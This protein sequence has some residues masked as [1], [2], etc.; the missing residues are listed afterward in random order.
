M[1]LLRFIKVLLKRKKL[2]VFIP[3]I[4]MMSAYFINFNA[5]KTYKSS[6]ILAAGII[7][8]T[9]IS[10]EENTVEKTSSFVIAT[11]FSNLIQMIK[12][13][14]VIDLV[15]YELL[16][17]DLTAEQPFRQFNNNSN[18]I[19]EDSKS[20]V[21]EVLGSRKNYNPEHPHE[22]KLY[23]LINQL[24]RNQGYTF[25]DISKK[26]KVERIG[27]SD[28]IRMNYESEN[29][30]LSAFVLNK[31]S[32]IF[33]DYYQNI[34]RQKTIGSVDFFAK[35]AEEKKR[36]LNELVDRLKQFKLDNKIINLYE[37]TKSIVN[38]ISELEIIRENE[39]KKVPSYAKAIEEINRRFAPEERKYIE[40][41]YSKNSREISEIKARINSL[42]SRLIESGYKN[43]SIKDSIN[44]LR[45]DLEYNVSRMSDNL[46]LNPNATK[47]NLVEKK[48][49]YELELEIAQQ[50]AK[51]NSQELTRLQKIVESFAPS[52]AAISSYER[53]ISVAAEAYLV[54]LNKLNLA[55][56]AVEDLGRS[57]QQT[58]PAFAAEKP[59][60]NKKLLIVLLVGGISFVLIVVIIFLMEY[61][62][63]TIKSPSRFKDFSGLTSIGDINQLN[64]NSINLKEIFNNNSDDYHIEYFK[65]ATRN[66]RYNI[67]KE[68]NKNKL[69]LITGTSENC[70]KSFISTTLAYSLKQ[71]GKKVLLIDANF[72]NNAITKQF[73]AEKSIDILLS[74][75]GNIF[76]AIT[77]SSIPGIDVIGTDLANISPGEIINYNKFKNSLEELKTEY[78]Y[79]IVET[80]S[81]NGNISA[82][83]LADFADHILLV[84][85]AKSIL[86]PADKRSIGSVQSLGKNYSCILNRIE[87]DDLEEIQGEPIKKRNLFRASVKKMI[88]RNLRVK[89][90]N[91]IEMDLG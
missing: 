86:E 9:K 43:S 87:F 58:E 55:R 42:S 78:D 26:L 17:H 5:P 16:L 41:E 72:K 33:I 48:I 32:D 29:K 36:E 13:K 68:L 52:E 71:I 61:I 21:T 2:L 73:N 44:T 67:T 53:E 54:I 25:E 76:S 22:E 30:Y 19:I 10:L 85:S 39:I 15:K 20:E 34:T 65:N 82:K 35:L 14:S 27:D 89:A 77:K 6:T 74:G 46:I 37:Q 69:I 23:N 4:G 60:P 18:V 28:F 47:Q 81:L 83:E 24:L 40:E 51:S 11:K 70:G 88:K 45:K 38:Q 63:L 90:D 64:M 50:S 7:D 57:I 56:F 8:D 12:S 66:L 59:E 80:Q 3:L 31:L 79:I 84:F 91:K 75:N 62:D 1:D 49:L